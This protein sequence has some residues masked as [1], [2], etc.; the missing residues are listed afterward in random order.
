VV[1]ISSRWLTLVTINT[2]G[3]KGAGAAGTTGSGPCLA[4]A[5]YD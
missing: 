2:L 4:N 1:G 3:A 5:V